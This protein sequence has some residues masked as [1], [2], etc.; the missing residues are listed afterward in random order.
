MRVCLQGLAQGISLGMLE[1]VSEARQEALV[2]EPVIQLRLLLVASGLFHALLA[3][4]LVWLVRSKQLEINAPESTIDLG[5]LTPYKNVFFGI[6][7]SCAGL[8]AL[9]ALWT[10]WCVLPM[11][12][13]M[14]AV[15]GDHS[16]EY[17]P[18]MGFTQR[19]A[20]ENLHKIEDVPQRW[21]RKA[22][23]AIYHKRRRKPLRLMRW[24]FRPLANRQLRERLTQLL[25]TSHR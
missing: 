9:T 7:Y 1:D 17:R 19:I 13:R 10:W 4:G 8:S 14:T 20:R 3:V 22:H 12:R 25:E 2:L 5:E 24:H 6:G 16:L 23:F 21:W 11:S 15:L 18:F